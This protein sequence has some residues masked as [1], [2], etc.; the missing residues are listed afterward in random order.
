[1]LAIQRGLY[2]GM[3]PDCCMILG[4]VPRISMSWGAAGVQ[5]LRSHADLSFELEVV[6]RGR[7][8]VSQ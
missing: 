7:H 5:A 4:L 8:T 2:Y 1:M 6:Y 3:H